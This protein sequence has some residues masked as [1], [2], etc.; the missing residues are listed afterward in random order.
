MKKDI[1]T[2][3][4]VMEEMWDACFTIRDFEA[5]E[6]CPLLNIACIHEEV[7]LDALDFLSASKI[8]QLLEVA[9]KASNHAYMTNRQYKEYLRAE[10]ANL[11]RSELDD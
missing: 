11:K 7:F 4:R 3:M 10:E 2:T 1:E 6:H 8:E 5:C 9:E